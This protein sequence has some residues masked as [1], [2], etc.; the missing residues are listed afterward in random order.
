MIRSI[1]YLLM[2]A[3]VAAALVALV[4]DMTRAQREL[5]QTAHAAR[6]LR[7]VLPAGDYDQAA[8]LEEIT[9]PDI[10]MTIY[11]VRRDGM[12]VAFALKTVAPNGYVGPIVLLTGLTTD[13]QIVAVRVASH[14]ETPGLG[15]KIEIGRSDWI[16]Q[17]AGRRLQPPGQWALQEEGGEFDQISGA[18]I[19]SRAVIN[20]IRD[21]V[22]QYTDRQSSLTAVD[23][24]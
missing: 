10:G 23:D 22:K 24:N 17:F 4:N 2:A 16:R 18:T 9:L 21:A 5:N 15:D 8:G 14:R 13:G 12:L 7:E 20:A 6:L 19:T 1:G 3:A 11:P